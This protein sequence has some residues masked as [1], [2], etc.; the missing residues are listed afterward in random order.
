MSVALVA[1]VLA[2]GAANFSQG[3]GKASVRGLAMTITEEFR[4]VRQEAITQRRPVAIVFPLGGSVHH[5]HSYYVLEGETMPL[6]VRTKNFTEEF[7]DA[8]IFIGDWAL[9]SGSSGATTNLV[10]VGTKFPG[11]SPATWLTSAGHGS[12]AAY[13]FLPDGTVRTNNQPSVDKSYR[14]VLAAGVKSSGASLNQCGEAFTISVSPGGGVEMNGGVYA[15]DGSLACN[16]SFKSASGTHLAPPHTIPSSGTIT[17]LTNPPKIYP[18]P[19]SYPRPTG[20]SDC[21]V[22]KDEFVTLEMRAT[23]DKGEQLYCNWQATKVSGSGSTNGKFSFEI[24]SGA[25]GGRMDWDPT[26]NSWKTVWQW[27]PPADADGGDIYKLTAEV[28]SYTAPSVTAEIPKVEIVP[29]GKV[30][31]QSNRRT[32]HWDL[33]SMKENGAS[34]KAYI[35][36]AKEPS[37]TTD[38]SRIAYVK[39]GNVWINFP[40]DPGG[41]IQITDEG[42]CR[43]PCISPSGNLVCYKRSDNKFYVRKTS[44]NHSGTPV[45]V[46]GPTVVS[47]PYPDLEKCCWSPDGTKFLYPSGDDIWAATITQVGSS[48]PN[49]VSASSL[50]SNAG[51][52]PISGVTWGPG[53]PGGA[54]GTIFHS[55]CHSPYDPWTFYS[56]GATPNVKYRN[57]TTVGTEEALPERCPRGGNSILIVRSKLVGGA[58]GTPTNRQI[59]RIDGPT[60]APLPGSGGAVHPLTAAGD[61]IRPIWTGRP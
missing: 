26:T 45:F 55:I 20:G 10:P 58:G 37:A 57:Y 40:M 19:S 49:L 61:N 21:Y 54:D 59:E 13:I 4:R 33:Y 30:L 53:G 36:D 17:P 51:G 3:R 42:D 18:D 38:G 6:V 34:E 15:Q 41:D 32:G 25:P 12:D 47:Q 44:P 11:F 9:R 46:G 23:S 60:G 16:G 5:T 1:L 8:T 27:R 29:P 52:N 56:G 39:G 22:G 14:L 7:G 50:L 35:L 43:I 48:P 2:L 28:K 24:P 31:F